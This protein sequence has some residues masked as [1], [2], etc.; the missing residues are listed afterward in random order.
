MYVDPKPSQTAKLVKKKMQNLQP[1]QLYSTNVSLQGRNLTESHSNGDVQRESQA[2]MTHLF[3]NGVSYEPSSRQEEGKPSQL[4]IPSSPYSESTS[5]FQQFT[6]EEPTRD[7]PSIDLEKTADS[8]FTRDGDHIGFSFLTHDTQQLSSQPQPSNHPQA[9]AQ[10]N[11]DPL[12]MDVQHPSLAS[13]SVPTA[14]SVIQRYESPVRSKEEALSPV[15]AGNPVA[16]QQR[17]LDTLRGMAKEYK[18]ELA[19]FEDQ[20][21][22]EERRREQ[23]EMEFQSVDFQGP[24]GPRD[25][26]T[27]QKY[28]KRQLK[29]LEEK[30]RNS[31]ERLKDIEVKLHNKRTRL[32]G[33][34]HQIKM[35]ELSLDA[36]ESERKIEELN[37]NDY[38]TKE[39]LEEQPSNK[40][41]RKEISNKREG[42]TR[43]I[44]QKG[45]EAKVI[46]SPVVKELPVTDS[47]TAH[48]RQ[49]NE[50]SIGHQK[51]Q[52]HTRHRN[53]SSDSSPK[54]GRHGSASSEGH[55]SLE[56]HRNGPIRNDLPMLSIPK[57]PEADPSQVRRSPNKRQ[58]E[59]IRY[60]GNHNMQAGVG[61][62][63]HT[64]Q[65]MEQGRKNFKPSSSSDSAGLLE[66]KE[67]QFSRV[68]VYNLS[69][70]SESDFSDYPRPPPPGVDWQNQPQSGSNPKH[71]TNLKKWNELKFRKQGKPNKEVLSPRGPFSPG[72]KQFSPSNQQEMAFRFHKNVPH[73]QHYNM[74]G[75]HRG[76]AQP[77]S[78]FTKGNLQ[79]HQPLLSSQEITSSQVTSYP[80]DM[81]TP[82]PYNSE[83]VTSET[84]RDSEPVNLAQE[85]SADELT[86]HKS[87]FEITSPR[88]VP[89]TRGP[90]QSHHNQ[91]SR[92]NY[93]AKKPPPPSS[94][95]KQGGRKGNP[96]SYREKMDFLMN[97][98]GTTVSKTDL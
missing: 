81:A 7:C 58:M 16:R 22:E 54:S 89:V 93:P 92:Q 94:K 50:S 18:S 47:L 29:E 40:P 80:D 13:S 28:K 49:V 30:R 43:A 33:I 51:D 84:T 19:I 48:Q 85:E 2:P 77:D 98:K 12:S 65:R 96:M 37:N 70:T 82:D 38:G 68:R 97:Y 74:E 87:S 31:N 26:M 71:D 90:P 86:H 5:I 34:E 32:Q 75:D 41:E 1:K 35:I 91:R 95:P 69:P 59:E 36:E 10:P 3:H 20:R 64:H 83:H 25:E 4:V 63:T 15:P 72:G 79:F 73:Y 27:T 42:E 23:L 17:N 44:S 60:P 56:R 55:R 67:E 6:Q 88:V 21:S 46:A 61:E 24:V 14:M 53:G 45:R 52:Q 66:F 11:Y 9:P 62:W 39:K 76:L 8:G 78:Y 57:N